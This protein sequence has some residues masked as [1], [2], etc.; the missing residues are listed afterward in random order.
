MPRDIVDDKGDDDPPTSRRRFIVYLQF[1]F[2]M[3]YISACVSPQWNHELPPPIAWRLQRLRQ[4]VG[5]CAFTCIQG[6]PLVVIKLSRMTDLLGFR[7]LRDAGVRRPL[8]R[9]RRANAP[10]LYVHSLGKLDRI[11]IDVCAYIY[12]RDR[13]LL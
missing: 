9:P 5:P 8:A 10:A 4:L 12:A 2:A 1:F 3:S 7:D 6:T 13:L 11:C